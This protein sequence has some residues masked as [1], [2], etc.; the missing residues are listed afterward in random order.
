MTL[1]DS[2]NLLNSV[3]Y[4]S[5]SVNNMLGAI[6]NLNNNRLQREQWNYQKQ[7][8]EQTMQR[9]D[10]SISRMIKDLQSAGLSKTLAA[11]SSGYDSG[12]VNAG[13]APQYDIYDRTA[14]AAS[15][16]KTMA[17]TRYVNELAANEGVRGQVMGAQA[18]LYMA[19]VAQ[20]EADALLKTGQAAYLGVS[21][22][23]ANQQINE[24]VARTRSYL[25]SLQLTDS[26]ISDIESQISL[27]S[28]Q[29]GKIDAET[30][31]EY[32]RR[33]NIN[34]STLQMQSYIDKIEAEIAGLNMDAK[35]KEMDAYYMAQMGT[36]MPFTDYGLVG[37]VAGNA[38]QGTIY[39]GLNR[40]F[41]K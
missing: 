23:V 25:K 11:G 16:Q 2:Q 21:A 33:R 38:I 4:A 28:A 24:S 40:I 14:L 9:E 17:D 32:A 3:N 13:T 12:Y 8:N 10:T 34:V 18:R 6:Q 37:D 39:S 1:Q 19:N 20:A 41:N 7:L 27:R 26:Q 22:R 15:L 29:E 31:T 36:K 5:Q 30:I 35:I